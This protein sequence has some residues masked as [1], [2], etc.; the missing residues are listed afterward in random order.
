MRTHLDEIVEEEIDRNLFHNPLHL[1]EMRIAERAFRYGVQRT[2]E[3]ARMHVSCNDEIQ[4]APAT[5]CCAG[6]W[7]DDRTYSHHAGCCG[8]AERRRG[9]RRKPRNWPENYVHEFVLGGSDKSRPIFQPN[10]YGSW[11]YDRRSG[12]DRRKP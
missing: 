8:R 5:E 1:R 3:W 9:E 2:T 7:V 4:P 6:N 10:H 11:F 12:K